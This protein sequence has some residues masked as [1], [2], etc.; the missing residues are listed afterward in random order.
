MQSIHDLTGIQCRELV[1]ESS[2]DFDENCDAPRFVKVEDI[3]ED[4]GR[5]ESYHILIVEDKQA[6]KFFRTA[7]SKGLTE[8][9]DSR[10][11]EHSSAEWEEVKKVVKQVEVIEYQEKD[12][13]NES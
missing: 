12:N 11:F 10:P 3:Y 4:S 8:Q 1:S 7:Y 2:F 5:W 6:N 13:E 9:Q